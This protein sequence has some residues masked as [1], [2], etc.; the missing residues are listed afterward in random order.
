MGYDCKS[1]YSGLISSLT[2]KH[3]K[4]AVLFFFNSKRRLLSYTN[5][6]KLLA[7]EHTEHTDFPEFNF[8]FH[9]LSR[10]C[11]I[12]RANFLGHAIDEV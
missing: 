5:L 12:Q 11:K 9:P 3:F 2:Q 6:R 8:P 10:I 4:L 1:Q 7:T